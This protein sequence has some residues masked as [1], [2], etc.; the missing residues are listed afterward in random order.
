MT[1]RHRTTTDILVELRVSP[2]ALADLCRRQGVKRLSVFG[3][4]AR[5]EMKPES[6]IDILIEFEEARKASLGD[7]SDVQ[8]ELV[9][10]FN[11]RKVDLTTPSILRNPYRRRSIEQDRKDL[12]AA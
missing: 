6:D 7:L 2:D 3:S 12:Y 1:Y 11:G 5:G 8:E 9:D 4:A 10:L